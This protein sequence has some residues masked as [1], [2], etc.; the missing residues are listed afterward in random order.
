MSQ[1]AD[2]NRSVFKH[3]DD[4]GKFRRSTSQF[5]NW[6]SPDASAEFPA[7]KD[8]YVCTIKNSRSED[9]V[10]LSLS[11]ANCYPGSIHQL[12]MPVGPPRLPCTLVER[13]RR[14]HPTC[15]Y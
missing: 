7:E 14:H 2:P 10:N 15:R 5:R 6:V 4:D 9:E 11:I 1:H 8:R 12:W 13:P 3:A